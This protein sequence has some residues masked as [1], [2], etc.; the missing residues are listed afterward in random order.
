MKTD[1][2]QQKTS[3]VGIIMEEKIQ[4]SDNH[5]Y[6][7]MNNGKIVKRFCH[8]PCYL[9][10]PIF[11][12]FG[13][14]NLTKKYIIQYKLLSDQQKKYLS[15][16]KI[17]YQHVRHLNVVTKHNK[18]KTKT[19]KKNGYY[20]LVGRN[21]YLGEIGLMKKDMR[22]GIFN[23]VYI[24]ISQ[25]SNTKDIKIILNDNT[26]L[27]VSIRS[28]LVGF[29]NPIFGNNTNI[30]KNKF[31]KLYKSLNKKQLQQIDMIKQKFDDYC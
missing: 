11:D 18:H 22:N 1:I 12:K 28:R 26:E 6:V 20:K 5:V 25:N 16:L 30:W 13:E 29:F 10:N 9:L 8:D 2:I 17:K 15:Q 4:S 24:I 3:N 7:M 19:K 23:K 27:I 31:Q 21:G 14:L